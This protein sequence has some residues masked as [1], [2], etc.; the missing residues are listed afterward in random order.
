[1]YQ[2]KPVNVEK[3]PPIYWDYKPNT[4]SYSGSI[5]ALIPV[6]FAQ[7]NNQDH[8]I[9]GI[10]WLRYKKPDG[11]IETIYTPALATTLK[12]A[13]AAPLRKAAHDAQTE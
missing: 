12:G 5:N 6:R 10:A 13:A 9:Y 4:V 8:Y 11:T 3:Y 2:N 1:M 7:K